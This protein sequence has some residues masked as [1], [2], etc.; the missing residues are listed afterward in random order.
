MKR[1]FGVIAMLFAVCALFM[2]EN[3][4]AQMKC[5]MVNDHMSDYIEYAGEEACGYLGYCGEGRLVGTFN[6]RLF[7][8][9]LWLDYRNPYGESHSLVYRGQA[10][11]ETMHGEIFTTT[12]GINYWETY[13][14]GGVFTNVEAHAVTGGTDHYEG[15]TGYIL[16]FYEYFPPYFFPATGK[17]TGEIC[18]PN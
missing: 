9:G 4:V 15:A 16:M 2:A 13:S 6:G 8:S 5:K 3:A 11:I 14:A 12:T 10:T 7:V 17:M 18:W 1:Q